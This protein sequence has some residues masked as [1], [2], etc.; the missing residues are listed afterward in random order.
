MFPRAPKPPR[1]ISP[2]FHDTTYHYVCQLEDENE[3]LR[4]ENARLVFWVRISGFLAASLLTM[5]IATWLL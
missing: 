2:D 1:P 5:R 4:A 3:E